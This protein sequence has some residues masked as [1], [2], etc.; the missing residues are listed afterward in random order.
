MTARV[1]QIADALA[2]NLNAQ[3]FGMA[4]TAKRVYVP[5][6]DLAD[7][8]ELTVSVM[9]SSH[10]GER[11]TRSEY[12]H[13]YVVEIG[14]QK[15]LGQGAEGEDPD[16]AEIGPLMDLVEEIGDYCETLGFTLADGSETACTEVATEPLYVPEHLIQQRVF[17]SVIALT[18]E[19]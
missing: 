15:K 7:L 5:K 19:V 9:A 3:A 6:V 12:S 13:T 18:F 2:T 4:F 16:P 10:V 11:A 14:V 1:I 8:K 17:T